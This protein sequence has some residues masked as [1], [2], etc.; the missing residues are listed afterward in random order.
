LALDQAISGRHARRALAW[1]PHGPGLIAD[2]SV[3][4]HFQQSNGA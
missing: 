4:N 1:E 2:L 3:R